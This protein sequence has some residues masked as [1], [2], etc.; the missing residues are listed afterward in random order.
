MRTQ[1]AVLACLVVLLP[2]VSANAQDAAKTGVVM[3]YPASF[4]VIWHVN[5]SVA[6]R[7]EATFSWASFESLDSSQPNTSNWQVGV[8]A[9]G[10]F[11]VGRHDNL[12]PY[13]SPQWRYSH[14][15]SGNTVSGSNNANQ[16][17]GMFGAQY[18]LGDRFG[19]FGETGVAYSRS[20][21]TLTIQT[22]LLPTSSMTRHTDTFGVVGRVGVILYF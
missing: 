17:N 2:S 12:R 11:Y 19:V 20:S 4:G 15:G 14:A 7:P 16:V 22:S 9:S 10:L 21:T 5:D 3:G 18:A 13:V 8:G 1:C 6:I